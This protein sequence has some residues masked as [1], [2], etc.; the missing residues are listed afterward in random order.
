MSGKTH[1]LEQVADPRK[2]SAILECLRTAPRTYEELVRDRRVGL[3]RRMLQ[4]YL[5]QYLPERG[6]KIEE[7]KRG[8]QKEFAIA[9][10][11]IDE[12][13]STEVAL[14]A[15][16][17]GVLQGLFPIEGTLFEARK[18][19]PV[20]AWAA[21]VPELTEHHHQVLLRWIRVASRTN[22]RAMM[23]NYR[24][25][26]DL[27]ARP[28][29]VWPIGVSLREGRRVYL[30]AVEE[31]ARPRGDTRNLALERVVYGPNGALWEAAAVHQVVP[32]WMRERRPR[33]DEFVRA[34]FGLVRATTEKM[35]TV[36]VRCSAQQRTYLEDRCWGPNQRSAPLPG[37]ELELSFGP[38]ALEEALGWCGQWWRGVTVVGDALLKTEWVKSL[39]ERLS[40]TTR[41]D[42]DGASPRGP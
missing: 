33:L 9:Q 32:G 7:R 40:A 3:E 1:E 22:L 13:A 28:R 29:L 42:A 39:R 21:G 4:V 18:S 35:V 25:A 24:S 34:P 16:A 36:R 17:R 37:G 11:A 41:D 23:L 14:L 30:H 5:N 19:A 27:E 20:L 6:Y 12:V 2:I 10:E 15:L 26:N 8:R 38:V 31:P